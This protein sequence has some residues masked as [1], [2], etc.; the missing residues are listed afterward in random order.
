MVL[1][2]LK[3][4]LTGFKE[5]SFFFCFNLNSKAFWAGARALFRLVGTWLFIVMGTFGIN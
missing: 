5:F 2:L 1:V 3:V 4:E